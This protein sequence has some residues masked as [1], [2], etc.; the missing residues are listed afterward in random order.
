MQELV[1]ASAHHVGKVHVP[2][3]PPDK[4]S[5][6]RRFL[7]IQS[8]FAYWQIV[9]NRLNQEAVP[10]PGGSVRNF[11]ISQFRRTEQEV[12]RVHPARQFYPINC[13]QI[14]AIMDIQRGCCERASQFWPAVIS[15]NR[16]HLPC[17]VSA[18]NHS[19]GSSPNLRSAPLPVKELAGRGD[20]SPNS[21]SFRSGVQRG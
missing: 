3:W 15:Q 2:I 13:K 18:L 11:Q 1:H 6:A 8:C 12:I 20:R 17:A 4:N 5:T 21:R 7:S 16:R 19:T 9:G 14:V 10:C